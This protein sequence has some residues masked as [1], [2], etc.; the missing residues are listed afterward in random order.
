MMPRSFLLKNYYPRNDME[1]IQAAAANL[2]DLASSAPA[3]KEKIVN[4]VLRYNDLLKWNYEYEKSYW[5]DTSAMNERNNPYQ[6]HE[7]GT[8]SSPASSNASCSPQ[9]YGAS[10]SGSSSSCELSPKES[11]LI[12]PRALATGDFSTKTF[13]N[14]TIQPAADDFVES[15]RIT[16][17]DTLQ[18][19][20]KV[21]E[22]LKVPPKLNPITPPVITTTP[23]VATTTTINTSALTDDNEDHLSSLFDKTLETTE[24]AIRQFFDNNR[25]NADDISEDTGLDKLNLQNFMDGLTDLPVDDKTELYRW[26][27]NKMQK[28]TNKD[29]LEAKTDESYT[30]HKCGKIFTYKSYL[31]RHIKYVCPDSA[32]R[33]WKCTYCGKAFQYPCYLRRHIR[34]HTGESPYKCDKCDRAFVRSTD[35]QRHIRNH[36]GEKPY[37][38][39]QCSRAFARSTD[40]KRHMRTHTGEKPYKCWQC[41]KSFSQ[42]GSL[43]THVHT[44][45]KEHSLNKGKKKLAL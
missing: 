16:E 19:E 28:L 31:E 45:S 3:P 36:T 4:D 6:P 11:D 13:M 41:G 33:T 44:H 38:C 15:A 37:R 17:S 21:P 5:F 23:P 26:Y 42:S 35:L 30:C 10:T 39:T 40:L 12:I 18:T 24:Q 22:E 8:S 2:L 34:S 14:T 43:Q 29:T 25:L 1:D 20:M 7:D 32:G 27:L 9:R